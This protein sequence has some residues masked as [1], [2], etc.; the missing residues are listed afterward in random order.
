MT[1]EVRG[2]GLFSWFVLERQGSGGDATAD[3]K[4][5]KTE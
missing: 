3:K 5:K 1:D 2:T 4:K